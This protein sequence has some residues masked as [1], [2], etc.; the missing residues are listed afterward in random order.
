VKAFLF[1]AA[2]LF[3]AHTPAA[4]Q[5]GKTAT[6]SFLDIK[7]DTIGAAKLTQTSSGVLIDIAIKGVAPGEHALHIHSVGKCEPEKKFESAGGH[8]DVG[9]HKHGYMAEGGPHAGDM[10]N[11]FVGADKVLH[12]QVLDPTVTLEQREGTLLDADGSA[13]VVHAK[14]DDYTTQS[15]GAAGARIACG[16]IKM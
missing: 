3:L 5:S 13:I 9:G 11:V 7:G 6:A 14:A 12:V 8:F 4:A 15:T 1:A 10:P 2:C 16:V